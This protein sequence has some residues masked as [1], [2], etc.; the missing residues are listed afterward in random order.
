MESYSKLQIFVLLLFLSTISGC[1]PRSHEKKY[2]T[3][4]FPKSQL[5]N[6]FQQMLHALNTN[7]PALFDFT[8]EKDFEKHIEL[9]KNKIRDSMSLN[10]FF[11]IVS[12]IVSKI[13]CAH[14]YLQFDNQLWINPATTVLP[15]RFL[16]INDRAFV[17]NSYNRDGKLKPNAEILQINGQPISELVK[18]LEMY[19]STD[20]DN[21]SGKRQLLNE[22]FPDFLAIEQNFPKSYQIVYRDSKND[23]LDKVVVQA[24]R[25]DDRLTSYKMNEPISFELNKEHQAAI[26]TIKSFAYYDSLPR[27]YKFCDSSFQ[28]IKHEGVE[29][30]IIDLRNNGGGDPFAAAYLLTYLST[31]PITYFAKPYGDYVALSKPMALAENRFTGKLYIL[32]NGLCSSTTGHLCALLKYHELGVFIGT[33]TGGTYT[34]NDNSKVFKL[35]NSGLILK[36][37]RNIYTVDVRG[38][39]RFRGIFPDY[40][41]DDDINQLT[42]GRDTVKEFAF[43][44]I[45]KGKASYTKH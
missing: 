36:T 18:N 33:E 10:G 19:I 16:L 40:F 28:T 5:I 45:K 44:L 7:H 21:E 6:D 37:A 9:Q 11:K 4:T 20:G 38:L 2:F 13:G 30:L 35:K 34:C 14:T 23:S 3:T 26:I 42:L 27:F 43:H 12:P 1:Q 41:I 24:L 22:W 32:I 29:N 15:V 39:P 8:N 31:Q 17:V 25:R